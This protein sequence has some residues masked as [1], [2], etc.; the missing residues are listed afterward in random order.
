MYSCRGMQIV[1]DEEMLRNSQSGS[2]VTPDRPILIDKFLE[3]ALETERMQLQTVMT[4]CTVLGN[5]DCRIHSGDS[6]CY[7]TSLHS[8]QPY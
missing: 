6:S 8:G 4:P 5:I 7:S 2:R 1:H 3:N